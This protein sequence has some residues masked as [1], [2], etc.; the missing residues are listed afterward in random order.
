M[1]ALHPQALQKHWISWHVWSSYWWIALFLFGCHKK[2]PSG[3]AASQVLHQRVCPLSVCSC[4]VKLVTQTKI[5][6][7]NTAVVTH[8]LVEE[9]TEKW[10]PWEVCVRVNRT[11]ETEEDDVLE[12]SLLHSMC[13]LN[14]CVLTRLLTSS[15]LLQHLCCPPTHCAPTKTADLIGSP[16]AVGMTHSVARCEAMLLLTPVK[17]HLLMIHLPSNKPF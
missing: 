7:G 17:P 10:Q 6:C 13:W 14:V 15:Y 2:R 9:L 8:C 11:C 12:K 5:F 16:Y 3:H 1:V 4:Y